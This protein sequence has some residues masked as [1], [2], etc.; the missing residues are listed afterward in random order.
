MGV[1]Y[2]DVRGSS[3][4]RESRSESETTFLG[5]GFPTKYEQLVY[6]REYEGVRLS[7]LKKDPGGPMSVGPIRIVEKGI[8]G[9]EPLLVSGVWIQEWALGAGLWTSCFQTETKQGGFWV[10]E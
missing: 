3:F 7:D 8:K 10:R 6:S 1:S 5:I 4:I 9:S 2:H